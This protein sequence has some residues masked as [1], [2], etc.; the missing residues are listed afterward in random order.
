MQ[1]EP[2][3]NKRRARRKRIESASNVV[4]VVRAQVI[5]HLGDV[6]INGLMLV[7]AHATQ[8]GAIHQF[9]LPLTGHHTPPRQIE[10]GVQAIWQRAGADPGR[11]WSGFR[12]IAVSSPDAAVLREWLDAPG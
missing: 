6:S 3:H 7:A 1:T 8:S 11:L 5:G 2:M 9:L 4:D 12:I 10:V